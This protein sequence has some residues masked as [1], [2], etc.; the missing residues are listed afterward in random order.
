[1]SYRNLP[2]NLRRSIG[3][4]YEHRY[5]GKMFDEA[6]ILAEVNECLHEVSVYFCASLSKNNHQQKCIH[7]YRRLLIS[8]VVH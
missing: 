7:L 5:R 6:S 8:I 1:M 2:R 4:Y 3:K